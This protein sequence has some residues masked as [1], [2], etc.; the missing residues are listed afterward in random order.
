[1]KKG[2]SV[3]TAKPIFTNIEKERAM[4]DVVLKKFAEV[5]G[6][7]EGAKVF[8]APGRVN[9]IG[10]L[11]G[12]ICIGKVCRI[13]ENGMILLSHGNGKLIHNSAVYPVKIVFGKLSD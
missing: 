7:G 10:E 13:Q 4:K 9:M 5:F 8:F 1:M 6:D 11:D 3:E 12:R 2:L